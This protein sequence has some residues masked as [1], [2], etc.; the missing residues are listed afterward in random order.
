MRDLPFLV[1]IKDSRLAPSAFVF[2]LG[3]CAGVKL[4][5]CGVKLVLIESI[6]QRTMNSTNVAE[7]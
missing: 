2:V 7:L 4:V 6:R 3:L 5:G 1:A